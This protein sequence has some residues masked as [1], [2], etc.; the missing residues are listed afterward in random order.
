MA[1]IA[2]VKRNIQRMIDMGAPEHDIDAY[3]ASEG[4]TLEQLGGKG[5]PSAET[6]PQGGNPDHWG[7]GYQAADTVTMGGSTKL[8]A[9]GQ[10]LVDAAFNAARGNGWN[11]SDAYN[12]NLGQARADQAAYGDQNPV[13][14]SL[15]TAAGVGLGITSMPTFG[16]GLL[17]AVGT[18]AAYG[19]AGGALQDANS[20]PE[21]A[22]NTLLG[23]GAGATI[24]GLGY[25]I[26]KAAGWGL[27]KAGD[28]ISAMRAPPEAQALSQF[29]KAADDVAGPYNAM[30]L[31]RQLNDLGPDAI[32]A[33]LLGKRGAALGR[34][35]SNIS[36]QAR[37]TLESVVQAR[38]AGQNVR[39]AGDVEAAAG[40]PAGSTKNVD[41]LKAEAYDAVRPQITAAYNAARK[42]G[43]DIPL[44][45]FDNIITTPVGRKAFNQALDNVTSRAARD[46]SAGGNLAVLDETKRL[47]DGWAS[48]AYRASD[49]MASEYAATAKALRETVDAFLANGQEYATARALRQQAYKAGDA[50]DLGAELGGPRV[51]LGVPEKVAKLPPELKPNVSKAYGATKVQSLLNKPSTEGAYNELITPQG[52]KAANAALEKPALLGKGIAREKTFNVTNREL[53]G[54]SSTARQ[55]AEMAGT[56]IGTASA[57][58]LLGFDPTTSTVA[59]SLAALGRRAV[60]TI[61]RKLV[62][63]NQRAVAPYLAN[64]LTQHGVST[65]QA[66]PQAQLTQFF[67]RVATNGDV[68]LAKTLAILWNH[69]VQN[70]NRQIKPAK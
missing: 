63:E 8:G 35:A 3:V 24:G 38:K 62:S 41:A 4:V 23:T 57:G 14:S 7:T 30:S 47:L 25:G 44:D 58:M 60:P 45:A 49:P 6:K 50:F 39:L 40:L 43:S 42:A 51:G 59:G 52:Q 17:G 65:S 37:E 16:R 12:Q 9:A 56:G 70:T 26:G 61:T 55:L 68:E 13:R 69:E 33:D 53:L 5:K 15:G 36:P 19:G 10:A 11:Y 64:L 67:S 31:S 18:G 28:V 1:D 34:G 54:N 32:N 22:S 21:R 27:D 2:K 20:L 29:Y 66:L 48:Q 46:P